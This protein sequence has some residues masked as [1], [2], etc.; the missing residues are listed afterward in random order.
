MYR[1]SAAILA[2]LFFMLAVAASSE[3]PGFKNALISPAIAEDDG[4]DGDDGGSDDSGDDN[5]DDDDEDDD[6]SSSSRGAGRTSSSETNT[7]LPQIFN[8][9]RRLFER[10]PERAASAPARPQQPRT[11][12]PYA[13][14]EIV[15]SEI[16]DDDLDSLLNQGFEILE[17][18]T[19]PGMVSRSLRLSIPQGVSMQDALRTIRSLPSGGNA[20]FNHFYRPNSNTTSCESRNCKAR[21]LIAWPTEKRTSGLCGSPLSIGMIDTGVNQQH[22][23]FQRAQLIAEQLP[24]SEKSPSDRIH[25][26]AVAALLVGQPDTRAPGLLPDARLIAIDAFH[27]AKRDERADV[28][29]LVDALYRLVSYDVSVIN[30]SLS[31]P[32]N[33]FLEKAVKD[34]VDQ[35][36]IVLVAAVGNNGPKSAPAYPSAYSE[37]IAVTAVSD[38][39]KIYR[40]ANRGLHVDLAAPG[41]RIWTAAS[42]KGAKW[43]TGTSFATPFVSAAAAL[44]RAKH[45]NYTALQIQEL[46][47]D[48]AE[49]IGA[50]GHDEIFGAGLLSLKDLC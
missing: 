5:D 37:V 29:S 9:I 3:L 8:P 42:I 10:Q 14:Q 47:K 12:A 4:D 34:L 44:A 2:V 19:F 20:D 33:T 41:V 26:T 45:P 11:L 13:N 49:D 16:S 17:E 39:K 31:G 40:R 43:K 24:M 27:K 23:V 36:D 15:I 21:Q 18:R 35:K 32:A 25:G 22:G 48:N 50:P 30:L 38:E 28:F 6:R 7:G 1:P 46:L